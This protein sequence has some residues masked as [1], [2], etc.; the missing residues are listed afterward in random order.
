MLQ[1]QPKNRPTFSIRSNGVAWRLIGLGLVSLGLVGC[2]AEPLT[3]NQVQ[4]VTRV[5]QISA[6]HVDLRVNRG[7]TNPQTGRTQRH[8]DLA[9]TPSLAIPQKPALEVKPAHPEAGHP[10]IS[11]LAIAPTEPNRVVVPTSAPKGITLAYDVETV[12]AII[13]GKAANTLGQKTVF[14][15]FDDGVNAQSTPRILDALKA[16]GVPAT[17]FVVGRTLGPSTAPLIHRIVDEGHQLAL[18]SYNHD[19]DQLYPGRVASPEAVAQQA[20]DSIA[21]L[22][23]ILGKDFETHVWRYPGG[24][25]SWSNLA[26]ADQRLAELGLHWID[27]NGMAGLA[28]IPERRPTSVEGI[29]R[30]LNNTL[31]YSPTQEVYVILMHDTADKLLIPQA[32]PLIIGN[33]RNQGYQFAVLK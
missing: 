6:S 14:L 11:R 28:D 31:Q 15:T 2:Q 5:P 18:H 17:F 24:H 1:D 33:F 13:E 8:G 29:W 12:K 30:Y 22:K 16:E 32:L 7:P 4:S 21:V 10:R 19:Y 25:M 26:P 3:L 27:W 20:Q 23:T 9:L